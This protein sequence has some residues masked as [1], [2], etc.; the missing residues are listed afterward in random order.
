[1][2]ITAVPSENKEHYHYSC[3]PIP[4]RVLTHRTYPINMRRRREQELSLLGACPL[5]YC[6]P[7]LPPGEVSCLSLSPNAHFYPWDLQK[8]ER[9]RER[10]LGGRERKGGKG[11]KKKR[12]KNRVANRRERMN[13]FNTILKNRFE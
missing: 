13:E 10:G 7:P 9:G 12:E 3:N 11:R 2:R 6:P 4:S 1:M 5:L 8:R